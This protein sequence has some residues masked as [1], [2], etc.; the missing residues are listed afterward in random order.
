MK[1]I[2]ISFKGRELNNT[3]LESEP[4]KFYKGTT[5]TGSPCLLS[6]DWFAVE[7]AIINGKAT[8]IEITSGD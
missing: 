4:G 3:S 7:Q 2:R 6:I 8:K 1:K 5:A